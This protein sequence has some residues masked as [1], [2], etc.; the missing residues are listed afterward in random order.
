LAACGRRIAL[1]V[2]LALLVAAIALSAAP[3]VA[4]AA[5]SRL[6]ISAHLGF[7]DTIKLGDW[8]PLAI[9]VTNNGSGLDGTVEVETSSS[10]GGKGGPPGGTAVYQTPISLATGATKHLRTQV[11]EDQQGS[12]TVRVIE[13]GRVVGSENVIPAN[14]T[15]VLIGVLSDQPS[16]LDGLA[17]INPGGFSTGVVH[18]TSADIPE[19]GLLLRPF[20]LLAIDDFATDTLTAGQ[21]A[22]IDDY[23]MNGGALLL[24]TGGS[25]HKTLGGLP[26]ATLPMQVTGS[27]ILVKSSA[28]GGLTGVEVASGSLTGSTPW[29]SE[30]NQPLLVEKTVGGGWVEMA[31]F[32][33]NQDSIAGWS[34][35]SALLRQTF[36]RASFGLTAAQVAAMGGGSSGG[37]LA[38]RGSNLSQV[39]SNL[40]S[41]DLPAW[42]LIGSLVLLYV[43]L[44]GPINYFVLRAINRRALAWITVPTI[45]L[46]A[47]GGAYGAGTLTKGR[48]VQAN[49]VSII[50]VASG[51]DRAYQ[52]AYTGILTPTRGDY[53]VGVGGGTTL[54][55]PIANNNGTL[56]PN[57]GLIRV[58]TTSG[59]ITLPGMTAFNLR[60]FATEGITTAPHLVAHATL[61][62]GKLT[63]TVQNLSST[64]FTD[65]VVISGNAYQ[66]FGRLAPGASADFSL[67]PAV[68]NPFNGPPA[69]MQIYPGSGLYGPPQSNTP[70]DV[71]RQ[72]DTK[73]AVL[74]MLPVNGFKGIS[75][76]AIPTVVVWSDLPF[77][78]ITVNGAHPRSYA[79]TG[80]VLTVPVDQIAAGKV[81]SGVVAGRLIDI[82]GAAQ[83]NGGPPGTVLMT[84]GA[85]TYDFIPSLG[86]GAH[87]DNATIE[88]SNPYGAKGVIPPGA[89]G[90]TATIKGQAWDWSQSTWVDVSYRDNG[91]TTVPGAAVN[92]KTGEVRLKLS[93]DGA[94]ASGW[95]SLAGVVQ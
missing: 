65:G 40:P 62:G 52:E 86:A 91:S 72:S 79:V 48:S 83:Q 87:L 73:S 82:D 78:D 64:S 27:S 6:T 1:R 8:M 20:D 17:S 14:T 45:A 58:D 75:L 18:L 93:S 24:G 95:L 38:Q 9:D 59:A 22:A 60:G 63:G 10:L 13:N 30:G 51:W 44:V 77:Q 46:V 25:W 23:V 85:V 61:V 43:L 66:T 32:D 31:T 74:S 54:V 41:L 47:A 34:G 55:S 76:S 69:F 21:R 92:P 15:A 70:T 11:T 68:S 67:I 26:N 19:S 53:G 7:H 39:L 49:E 5:A 36:I 57:Q 37:S 81:P 71:Q 12:I 3:I 33:W 2:N 90:T 42:W 28:L 29:L 84:S 80:V 94:Y 35:T 88:S 16:S 89:N 4:Q 56:D 50:H